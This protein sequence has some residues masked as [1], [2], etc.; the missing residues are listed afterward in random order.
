MEFGHGLRNSNDSKEGTR[1]DIHVADL[2]LALPLEL[3]LFDIARYDVLVQ[4]V[5]NHWS[6]GLS[7]GNEGS[8]GFGV[9]LVLL[10]NLWR[11]QLL[12]H[13]GDMHGQALVHFRVG[14][15]EKQED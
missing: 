6:V 8:H 4:L 7:F 2:L 15:V 3:S 12:M 14:F 13:R 9:D 1:R 11:M 5:G 10:I